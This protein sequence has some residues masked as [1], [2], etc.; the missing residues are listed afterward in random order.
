[1]N[2]SLRRV[3]TGPRGDGAPSSIVLLGKYAI[4]KKKYKRRWKADPS[5][6][7]FPSAPNRRKGRAAP[8]LHCKA[9]P[10]GGRL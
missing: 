1:M 3:K 2:S 9:R 5:G 4:L 7:T 10:K 6:L 8:F